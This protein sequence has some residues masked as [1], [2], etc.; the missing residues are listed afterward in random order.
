MEPH[1]IS[2]GGVISKRHFFASFLTQCPLGLKK[3]P[4]KFA[5]LLSQDTRDDLKAMIKPR[6][7]AQLKQ[8]S[9]R[10]RLGVSRPIDEAGDARIDQRARAHRTWLKSYHQR[11]I[12]KPPIPAGLGRLAQGKNLRMRGRISVNLSAV[13]PPADDG[14]SRIDDEAPHRRLA[15][16]CRGGR[17][18]NRL[19]HGGLVVY[20]VHNPDFL[21]RRREEREEIQKRGIH[22]PVAVATYRGA[23]DAELKQNQIRVF[24]LGVLRASRSLLRPGG[25]VAFFDLNH[26]FHA[27]YLGDFLSKAAPDAVLEGHGAARAA[28]AGAVEADLH[29]SIVADVDQFDIPPV[30]LHR[31][32]DQID[33]FQHLIVQ[34][35]LV[36]RRRERHWHPLKPTQL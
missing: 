10:P 17:Q 30:G 9:H 33:H 4:Q 3:L 25:E 31:R 26:R 23:E 7:V 12:R 29:P 13:M 6:I 24:L 27:G 14:A 22:R 36:Y 16:L 18:G 20:R 8:R 34:R 2:S 32:A 35:R 21:P 5:A 11:A 15:D 1:Y 19:P 28:V